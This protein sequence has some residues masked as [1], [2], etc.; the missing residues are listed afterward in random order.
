MG[1][2]NMTT[3]VGYW[4]AQNQS[5]EF[6]SLSK[7]SNRHGYGFNQNAGFTRLKDVTL[8]Y[9]FPAAICQKMKI[10]DLMIYFSGRNLY[11]WTDWT[12]WDPEARNIGRGM[13]STNEFGNYVS[14]EDNYP[15]TK[16]YT[17]GLNITF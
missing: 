6:R 9:N 4:T 15:M 11:T 3:A 14:W 12:G 13:G 8:S 5:N 10:S 7:T 16:S 1:R 17:I 2:R